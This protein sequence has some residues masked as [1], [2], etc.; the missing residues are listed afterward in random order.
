MTSLT[1]PARRVPK[2]IICLRPRRRP[3]LEIAFTSLICILLLLESV[4]CVK[5]SHY[6]H[7]NTSNP[8]FRIDNTDH[9]IDINQGNRPW[10]YDQVNIICPVY[11]PGKVSDIS[12]S[13]IKEQ[14]IIYSVSREEYETCRITQPH[15]RVIAVCDKPHELMYFT[16]T[17][18]SFTPT[19]GG[20]EFAPGRDYYFI[21]T[22][23]RHDL[24]QRSG[25]WCAS[26]HMKVAF[27]VADNVQHKEVTTTKSSVTNSRSAVNEPRGSAG[28]RTRPPPPLKPPSPFPIPGPRPSSSDITTTYSDRGYHPSASKKR[29]EFEVHPNDVVKQMASPLASATSIVSLSSCVALLSLLILLLR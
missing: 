12:E 25:G 26:H 14:A 1:N 3:W 24:N 6:I 19:P 27:K 29:N 7:W 16:I 5:E 9:I 8:M 17:F 2:E 20:L 10:E 23:S 22:S 13:G 11:R 21:S 28:Y 15:P 18:R 4:S